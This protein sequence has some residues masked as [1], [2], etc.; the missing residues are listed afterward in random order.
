MNAK[1]PKLAFTGSDGPLIENKGNQIRDFRERRQERSRTCDEKYM[2]CVRSCAKE[3][4]EP[5]TGSVV[6]KPRADVTPAPRAIGE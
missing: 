4:S 5:D 2:T 6:L 3:V 1:I